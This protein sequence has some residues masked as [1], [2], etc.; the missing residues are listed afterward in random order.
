MQRLDKLLKSSS[1]DG[2]GKWVAKAQDMDKLAQKLRSAL[3]PALAETLC[4]VNVRED[5]ELVLV[6]R[7]AGAA[8]RV[9]FEAEALIA[10]ARASGID[11]TGCR[12]R[13]APPS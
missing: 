8:S 11:V 5:G 4:A 10:A 7:G 12:V 9:R 1:D 6:C 13:V 2:L 3:D